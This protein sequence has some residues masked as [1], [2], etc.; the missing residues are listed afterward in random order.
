M[1]WW[2]TDYQLSAEPYD[3]AQ[4]T[5]AFEVVDSQSTHGKVVRQMVLEM[6][7]AWCEAEGIGAAINMIGDFD[8]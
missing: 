2:T 8:W 6:P 7:V 5:G 3:L 1:V 4:Q